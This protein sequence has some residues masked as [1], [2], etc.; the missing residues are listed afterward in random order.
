MEDSEFPK[1]VKE[2]WKSR[3]AKAQSIIPSPDTIQAEVDE[4]IRG[5]ERIVS[6]GTEFIFEEIVVI[7]SERIQIDLILK[8]PTKVVDI[9]GALLERI[10]GEIAALSTAP[11]NQAAFRSAKNR[12][13][14]NW[15]SPIV[16][17][18]IA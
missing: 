14:K 7:I 10:D 12:V 6:I 17:Q 18:L 1:N 3:I 13:R 15:G 16:H 2:D 11:V 4:R 9:D 8:L 5:L